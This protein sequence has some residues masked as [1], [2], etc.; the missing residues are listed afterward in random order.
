MGLTVEQECP[1]CGAPIELDETDNIMLCPYCGVKNFLFAPHFYRFLLPHKAPGK[2]IFYTPYLR[3]KGNI[4]FCNDSNLTCRYLDIT[5]PGL[6]HK[7]IPISLGVRPQAMKLRFFSPDA[8]GSFLRFSIDPKEILSKAVIRPSHLMTGRLFHHAYIGEAL[9]VVY[10]PVFVENCKIFDAVLNRPLAEGSDGAGILEHPI[11]K[12]P[13]RWRIMFMATL[14]PVCGWNLDG[15]RDSVVLTCK[16]CNSAWEAYEAKFSQVEFAVMPGDG[17]ESAYL[18]FWKISVKVT[19]IE[20]NSFSDFIRVTNQPRIPGKEM[21]NQDMSFWCPAFKIRP[22]IFL[23]LSRQSTVSQN[24]FKTVNT[25]PN[26]SIYPVTLPKKE[27]LQ[28]MK[29]TLAASALNKRD[30]FPLLPEVRFKIKS[31]MLVY[32]P[33]KDTGHE[34]VHEFTGMSINK[35]IMKFGRF[36]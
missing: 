20:I 31:S 18:P 12:N 2:E 29:I 24:E 17:S 7:G 6:S 1:Q 9:S 10:L 11:E 4:Y 23:N 22:K 19:G 25:F 16:N 28:S 26:N 15:E 13:R 5:R 35:N 3:F 14:C 32:L 21:E 27:A 8:N 30:I 33:F 34:M 36:L